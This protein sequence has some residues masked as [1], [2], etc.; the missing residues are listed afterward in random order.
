VDRQF[1]DGVLPIRGLPEQL[2]QVFVNLI[3]NACHAMPQGG[4]LTISTELVDADGAVRVL[5]GDTGHGISTHH[6]SKIFTPFFTTK[7]DGRG[8]GL[9][10]AIVKSI[11]E[12]HAG[13]IRVESEPDA[14]TRFYL[15][16]PVAPR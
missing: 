16:L 6:Q 11:I 3:T 7:T 8:T 13:E 4:V 5:V 2:T 1:G 10:L 14:G 12:G 9:G 15:L